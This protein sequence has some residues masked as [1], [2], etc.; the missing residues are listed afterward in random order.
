MITS[1]ISKL[2]K[3]G[4]GTNKLL[5]VIAINAILLVALSFLFSR[6]EG[7][8]V[9]GYLGEDVLTHTRSLFSSGS[10][11]DVCVEI[12]RILF[13]LSFFIIL[14]S[15]FRRK[16]GSVERVLVASLYALQILFLM[17]IEVGSIL[18][19]VIY[20]RNFVLAL[21]VSLLVFYGVI[22]LILISLPRSPSSD[23]P[24]DK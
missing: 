21:W 17:F 20:G 18:D 11:D 14:F 3:N 5:I 7:L 10:D 24:D 6:T 22:M 12:G 19:T 13:S 15:I 8:L 2:S 4:T 16:F 9:K 23:N 1:I